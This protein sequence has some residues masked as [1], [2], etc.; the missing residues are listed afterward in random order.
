[1]LFDTLRA[2][3]VERVET[4]ASPTN[5]TTLQV[6]LRLGFKVTGNL[7]TDRWGA[8]V[9]LTKFLSPNAERVF[10]DGYCAVRS[11]RKEL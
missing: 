10:V 6:A 8:L 11:G 9:R 1:M 5:A 3:G 7:T 2:A 4:D